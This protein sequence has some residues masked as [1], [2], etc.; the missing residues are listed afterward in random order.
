ML[1]LLDAPFPC[2]YS[3][4][5][6]INTFTF[7]TAMIVKKLTIRPW[8]ELTTISILSLGQGHVIR[9]TYPHKNYQTGR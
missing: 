7:Y 4:W 8:Q 9:R 1:W 2:L 3:F 5:Q 6:G